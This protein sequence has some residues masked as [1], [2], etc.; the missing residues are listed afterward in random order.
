MQ[1]PIGNDDPYFP[2]E[3]HFQVAVAQ[4]SWIFFS[5][6]NWMASN[7]QNDE[8]VSPAQL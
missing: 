3:F 1:D 5:H 4:Y 2:A 8:M 7:P 6:K